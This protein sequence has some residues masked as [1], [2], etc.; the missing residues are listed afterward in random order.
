MIQNQ[1][2]KISKLEHKIHLHCTPKIGTNITYKLKKQR[3]RSQWS[4]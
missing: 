3:D 4:L 2:A 1:P